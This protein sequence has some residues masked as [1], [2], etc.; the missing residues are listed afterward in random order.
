[1]AEAGFAAKPA[2]GCVWISLDLLGFSRLLDSM[3][4]EEA[5]RAWM[6]MF[7]DYLAA[8]RVIAPVLTARAGGASE[9][10]AATGTAINAALAALV[11]RARAAGAIRPDVS[12]KDLLRGLVGAGYANTDPDWEASA[13][14]LIDVLVDGLTMERPARF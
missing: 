5:L 10:F 2:L 8:K 14:R 9:I 6:L 1:M 7:V 12:P 11:D 4:P 13:R 3:P